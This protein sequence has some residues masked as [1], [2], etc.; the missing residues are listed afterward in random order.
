LL[1][2]AVFMQGMWQTTDFSTKRMIPTQHNF[3]SFIPA[4]ARIVCIY[5]IISCRFGSFA[6]SSMGDVLGDF[7]GGCVSGFCHLRYLG[8]QG[9]PLLELEHKVTQLILVHDQL[10]T[11]DM[12]AQAGMSY[13]FVCVPSAFNFSSCISADTMMDNA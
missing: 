1:T 4:L 2:L 9:M 7:F 3:I 8:F 11:A 5:S 13:L 6:V 12:N 10:S